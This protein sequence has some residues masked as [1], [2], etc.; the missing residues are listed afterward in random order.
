MKVGAGAVTLI[1][2]FSIAAVVLNSNSKLSDNP[3][4]HALLAG[5]SGGNKTDKSINITV[6]GDIRSNGNISLES[7]T[8]AVNGYAAAVSYVN[9]EISKDNIYMKILI[10]LPFRMYMTLSMRLPVSIQCPKITQYHIPRIILHWQLWHIRR[11][12]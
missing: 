8:V 7:D 9:A 1:T 3:R 4:D 12:N 6:N 5:K 11:N 10:V 2:A